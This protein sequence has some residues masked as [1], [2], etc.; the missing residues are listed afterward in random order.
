MTRIT[1]PALVSALIINLISGCHSEFFPGTSRAPTGV[2][3]DMRSTGKLV[4]Q[5]TA[6]WYWDGLTE[7]MD[8][9]VI[10]TGATD[11]T[12]A[13]ASA[14]HTLK[15]RGWRLNDAFPSPSVLMK[16]DKWREVE[17]SVEPLSSYDPPSSDGL[18]EELDKRN[19]QLFRA[20]NMAA[21]AENLVVLQSSAQ[22]S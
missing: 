11:T 14:T 22:G 15:K 5:T 18:N 21:G 17:V 4:A 9:L 7:I 6:E 3:V 13:L 2:V 19:E 16:S 10:D 1:L 12:D 8:V 20:L